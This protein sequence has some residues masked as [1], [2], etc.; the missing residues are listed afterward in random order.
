MPSTVVFCLMCL[1]TLS[2]A[3]EP[4]EY[5]KDLVCKN[6][7]CG[8]DICLKQK[9][10]CDMCSCSDACSKVKC[11]SG[12]VCKTVKSRGW[13][14]RSVATCVDSTD[15]QRKIEATTT[16]RPT[17]TST[18]TTTTP[19]ATIFQRSSD[20]CNNGRPCTSDAAC[21][22]GDSCLLTPQEVTG[23]CCKK[24]IVNL[25]PRCREAMRTGPCRA[26]FQKYFYNVT[27]SK[28][29]G[30][31]YGGCDPSENNFDSMEGCQ[32]ECENPCLLPLDSGICRAILRNY[33]YNTTSK[34]C[35]EFYYGGCGG[36]EN[37][38]KSLEECQQRCMSA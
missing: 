21:D 14:A 3:A 7:R 26:G 18:T 24:E 12:Q 13:F 1:V 11:G 34:Q 16:R 35:E 9:M 31:F 5:F 30:F 6:F 8:D 4:F 32:Q 22:F 36:N 38:W 28:C 10:W 17:T 25:R 27:S 15:A 20:I 2:V 19:P 29:Q 37:N 33:F 23:T